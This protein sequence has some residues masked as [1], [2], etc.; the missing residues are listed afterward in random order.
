MSEG[1]GNLC[2]IAYRPM[3]FPNSAKEDWVE[4]PIKLHFQAVAKWRKGSMRA[5]G[6]AYQKEINHF[7]PWRA[8]VSESG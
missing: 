1:L 5:V 6:Q 3:A 2:C 4:S 7:G 8:Q